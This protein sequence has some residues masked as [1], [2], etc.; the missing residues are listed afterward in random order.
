MAPDP[1]AYV[2]AYAHEDPSVFLLHALEL[3]EARMG[4]QLMV[5]QARLSVL[6]SAHDDL[7]VKS[8][9]QSA[10][11]LDLKTALSNAAKELHSD[12]LAALVRDAPLG[13]PYGQ[14]KEALPTATA[15]VNTI[16]AQIALQGESR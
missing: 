6:V 5:A 12:K 15:I 1:V 4:T 7:R 13:Q 8:A 10:G 9:R 14:A 16:R 3:T 11:L 2:H